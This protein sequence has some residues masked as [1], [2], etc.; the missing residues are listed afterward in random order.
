MKIVSF[1][2]FVF[3]LPSISSHASVSKQQTLVFSEIELAANR[4]LITFK[5]ILSEAYAH[6]GVN[7]EWVT[8]PN[9]RSIKYSN[10]GR[11][12]GELLRVERIVDDY[13]NLIPVP[14]V[15]AQGEFNLYCLLE[16]D[17]R[18]KNRRKITIGYSNETIMHEIIC[19][20]L[21]L[22]CHPFYSY[23]NIFEPLYDGKIDAFLAHDLQ[24]EQALND[25]SPILFQSTPLFVERGFHFLHKKH[26]DLIPK[27]TEVLNAQIREGRT[28]TPLPVQLPVREIFNIKVATE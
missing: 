6:I 9:K 21:S 7:I 10:E 3:F 20:K 14:I 17:C 27:I 28:L 8:V 18:T 1:C 19:E 4:H 24:I 11:F 2:L 13:P 23:Q 25:K 5:Q 15:L 22:N 12:D 16:K 26:S